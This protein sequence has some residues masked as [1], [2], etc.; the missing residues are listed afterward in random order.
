MA[1]DLDAQL[2]RLTAWQYLNAVTFVGVVLI[3]VILLI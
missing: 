3:L 1:I 2:K